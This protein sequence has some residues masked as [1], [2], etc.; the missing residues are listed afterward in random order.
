MTFPEMIPSGIF[1]QMDRVHETGVPWR[2]SEMP[3]PIQREPG[4]PVESSLWS[5]VW[6]PLA[7]AYPWGRLGREVTSSRTQWK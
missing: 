7:G 4:G 2:V 5:F 6:M 1:E 3:L